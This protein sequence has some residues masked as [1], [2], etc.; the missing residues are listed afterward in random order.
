[1]G[2]DEFL[3]WVVVVIGGVCL[4]MYGTIAMVAIA[5]WYYMRSI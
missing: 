3:L 2:S 4:T 1:M 5:D